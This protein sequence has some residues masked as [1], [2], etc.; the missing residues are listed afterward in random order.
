MPTSP[1]PVQSVTR[2]LRVLEALA[3]G[4]G[5]GDGGA[6]GVGV[7]ELARATGLSAP[8]VHRLL[9]TLLEEGYVARSEGSLRYRLGPRLFSLAVSAESPLASVRERV[10]P[11]MEELRDRFGE[12]VNLAVLDRRH[13][14]Y[15]HQVESQRSV[16]AFNRIGNRVLA[17]ASAAGKALLAHAPPA[18]LDALLD[19]GELA[20]LTP[21]T[22]TSPAA[23]SR[24]LERVRGRGYALDLGEQDAEIVCVAAAVPAVGL[25]PAAAVSVSGPALRVRA[26]D[27]DT[28]GAELVRALRTLG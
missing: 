23:L 26:L 4:A 17:H 1:Q 18:T 16:R 13:I 10:A 27:L 22:L 5:R 24:D 7:I 15:V 20:A 11:V 9:A 3:E 21:A 12:T 14:V 6:G 8:T 25:R 19:S 2:A 28:V